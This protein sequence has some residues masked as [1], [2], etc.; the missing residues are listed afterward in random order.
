MNVGTVG[1]TERD[2]WRPA[3]R[4][5]LLDARILEGIAAGRTTAH[6][7]AQLHLSRQGVDYHITSLLRRFTVPNRTALAS[8]AHAAGLFR[9]GEWPPRV[10]ENLVEPP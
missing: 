6:L 9:P 3:V 10:C 7:A 5:T 2:A 1:S 4:L 8:R